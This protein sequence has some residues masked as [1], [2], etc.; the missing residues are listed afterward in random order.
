VIV[1]TSTEETEPRAAD[2][3][4]SRPRHVADS[5]VTVGNDPHVREIFLL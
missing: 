1:Q 3:H 2:T 5:E 4:G